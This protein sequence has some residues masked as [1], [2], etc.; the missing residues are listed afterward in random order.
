[1]KIAYIEKT[2][3]KASLAKIEQAE[4]IM[5]EYADAGYD[6]TLRQLYYQFVARDLIPNTQR[7]YKNLGT[8][9]ND[10]RLAGHLDWN[11]LVDRTRSYEENSHW[12]SPADI[13]RACA[14]QFAVDTR[15]DQPR[16]IEVWVEK[17]ALVGVVSQACEELD[18]GYVSCRGYVS[19]SLMWRAAQRMYQYAARDK[20]V[21]IL[22]MGDHDPS[23][24]DMTRDIEGRL[25]M[26]AAPYEIKVKRI[27]L[28]MEQIEQYQPPPNPAKTTDSRYESYIIEHGDESWELDA[29]DP[30]V[31]TRLIDTHVTD[32]TDLDKRAARLEIQDAGRERLRGV[33]ADL[34]DE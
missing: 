23:G 28:N 5:A 22:H 29:L 20:E 15:K 26:F 32:L 11:M 3:R 25:N 21:V 6:L 30:R 19:Q 27:A 13:V 24:I 18:V 34:E 8:I 17:D 4:Q 7:E 31:L 33:V 1:M 9:I 2:F 16:H 10:A 14:S 12:Q